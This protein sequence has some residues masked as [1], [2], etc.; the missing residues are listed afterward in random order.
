MP[1]TYVWFETNNQ[2][3]VDRWVLVAEEWQKVGVLIATAVRDNVL[4]FLPELMSAAGTVISGFKTADFFKYSEGDSPYD[5]DIWGEIAALARDVAMVTGQ[6]VVLDNETNLNNIRAQGI[7]FIDS[8]ALEAAV[9]SSAWPE[10]WF[11]AGPLG[12]VEPVRQMSWD[13]A[14]GM[15]GVSIIHLIEPNSAGYQDSWKPDYSKDNFMRTKDLDSSPMSIIYLD[16]VSAWFWPLNQ[17]CQALGRAQGASAILYPGAGDLERYLD[18]QNS[19][20]RCG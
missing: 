15:T 1:P 18:V 6:P 19:V 9:A 4:G 20:D 16:D 2:G 3:L 12:S 14:S 11:W 13:F 5:P 8:S 10:I 7:E 17:T